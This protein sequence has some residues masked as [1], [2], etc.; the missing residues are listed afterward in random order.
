MIITGARRR[1]GAVSDTSPLS[2][3]SSLI[4]K[5][6]SESVSEGGVREGGGV[7]EQFWLWWRFGDAVVKVCN[8][9]TQLL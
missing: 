3:I 1:G 4:L 8:M 6:P 5:S 7:K 9:I 2:E